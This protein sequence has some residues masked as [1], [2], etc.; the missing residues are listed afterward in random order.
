[1]HICVYK[2]SLDINLQL[3]L[4][5]VAWWMSCHRFKGCYVLVLGGPYC[6]GVHCL[7]VSPSEVRVYPEQ[8]GG[9]GLHWKRNYIST[10][11]LVSGY[12]W[13]LSM[14]SCHPWNQHSTCTFSDNHILPKSTCCVLWP[15]LASYTHN[16]HI[17]NMWVCIEYYYVN[18]PE[19]STK[20]RKFYFSW[21]YTVIAESERIDVMC[22]RGWQWVLQTLCMFLLY[23]SRHVMHQVYTSE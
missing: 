1:M 15:P 14:P 8:R 18:N 16:R 2:L 13:R 7:G 5:A 17:N 6:H 4:Q 19:I 21:C 3:R 22:V 12:P 20:C 10:S 23:N 9:S 11:Y